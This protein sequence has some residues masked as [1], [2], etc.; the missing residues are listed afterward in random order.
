MYII[1]AFKYKFQNRPIRKNLC[2]GVN[3]LTL[4][5]LKVFVTVV[6][7]GS[8]SR[9]GESL[10]ISQPAVTTHIKC[11]EEELGTTLLER[12]REDYTRLTRSGRLI[13]EKATL[14]LRTIA[15]MR[16]GAQQESQA[17]PPTLKIGASHSFGSYLLPAIVSRFAQKHPDC[18]ILIQTKSSQEILLEMENLDLGLLI[19]T[20]TNGFEVD[21]IYQ[22]E[23]AFIVAPS[24]PQHARSKPP[25]LRQL[26]E[27]PMILP[28]RPCI[29][30]KFIED[31]L[32][33]HQIFPH[34]VLETGYPETVKQAV[35]SRIGGS[36]ICHSAIQAELAAGILRQIPLQE[37]LYLPFSLIHKRKQPLTPIQEEFVSFL[38]ETIARDGDPTLTALADK[39]ELLER[40]RRSGVNRRPWAGRE[41]AGLLRRTP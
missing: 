36:L 5:Q 22:E 9:A 29:A 27:M 20:S 41:R 11:L 28:P 13:Y 34:V 31:F 35:R 7:L 25:S 14:I 16:T 10:R 12:T 19:L 32:K 6:E 17:P 33:S 15:A 30:R 26:L 18:R 37:K 3:K 2:I 38:R 40:G 8:F 1:F 23:M 21:F 4:H 39:P 24:H